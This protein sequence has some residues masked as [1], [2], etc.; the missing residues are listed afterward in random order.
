MQPKA[1]SRAAADRDLLDRGDIRLLQA[2]LRI[3]GCYGDPTQ[4]R[5]VDVVDGDYGV[6]TQQAV[7]RFARATGNRYTRL[8]DDLLDDVRQ[9]YQ[10]TLLHPGRTPGRPLVAL[11]NAFR[12]HYPRSGDLWRQLHPAMRFPLLSA[13]D[14]LRRQGVEVSLM[15]GRRSSSQQEEHIR[16]GRSTAPPGASFHD[17]GLA[18]DLVPRTDGMNPENP[19]WDPIFTTMQ[20]YGFYS[21][22]RQQGWDRPH[23]ELP[24][25]TPTMMRWTQDAQGWKNIPV[26]ALPRVWQ[27]LNAQSLTRLSAVDVDEPSSPL[28]TPRLAGMRAGLSLQV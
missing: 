20:R 24:A 3:L 23:F 13:I 6:R 10:R 14:D 2:Y 11:D 22:Y 25:S 15:D 18:I 21:L 8:N 26:N 19:A 12:Q 27:R 9:H 28:P 7:A 17:Y 16:E 1:T 5:G 4:V